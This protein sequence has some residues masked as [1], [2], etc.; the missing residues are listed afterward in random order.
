[1]VI[2]SSRV[3]QLVGRRALRA[4]PFALLAALAACAVVGT[5]EKPASGGVFREGVVGQPLSLNPLLD[6]LDPIV[7]DVSRLLFAGLVRVTDG[8]EIQGDLAERWVTEDDGRTYVFYLRAGALWHDSR[9]VTS[10]DIAST[11]G[12]LQAPD[13]PGPRELASLWRRVRVEASDARTVR[14]R[15]DEPYASFIE[16]CSVPI[17]PAHQFRPEEAGDLRENPSSYQPVGAGPFKLLDATPQGLRLGRH[18][19]YPGAQPYVQEVQFHYFADVPTAAAALKE[20]LVDG[21]AGGPA[22]MFPA[23]GQGNQIISWP[24]PLL[25]NQIILLMNHRNPLLADGR[26]RLAMASAIDRPRLIAEVAGSDATPAYGPVPS[27][28]W[29]YTPLV[30]RAPDLGGGRNLLDGAGWLGSP[31]RSQ[32]ARPLRLQ[33]LVPMDDRLVGFAEGVRS[34]LQLIGVQIDLQPTE[35]RDLYRERLSARRFDLALL[36][37]GLGAVDPDPYQLWDSSQAVQGFNFVSYHRDEADALLRVART[38]GDPGRRRA[39]L[40]AFQ[41]LWANDV[42]SI[43]LASPTLTYAVWDHIH[44]VRLG[45]VPEPGARLQHLAEWYVNTERGLALFG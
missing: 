23:S 39:A 19:G 5:V 28:S 2:P 25:G 14:F 10:A 9:P 7:R 13:Y 30:E 35:L 32:G 20:N 33:L 4:A 16:A 38:D 44:G 12:I 17:L 11:I 29:A 21:F 18:S 34:Q 26:I 41:Q 37:I 15:L 3:R 6:P 22:G 31:L 42:P 43:V 27:Y 40:E 36:N 45:V 8:G 1:M 24:T